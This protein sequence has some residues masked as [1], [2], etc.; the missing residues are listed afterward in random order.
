MK[1][2]TKVKT[3]KLHKMHF[4]SVIIAVLVLLRCIGLPSYS[5]FNAVFTI[6][7]VVLQRYDFFPFCFIN[8]LAILT[9][10]NS[11]RLLYPENVEE[12]RKTFGF[13]K[14][15][16]LLG[17]FLIHMIPL[18]ISMYGCFMVKKDD[19]SPH[20]RFPGLFSCLAHLLWAGVFVGDFN[21]SGMYATLGDSGWF[22]LWIVSI[23]TH[24]IGNFITPLLYSGA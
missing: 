6:I 11:A 22:I 12:L 20:T 1:I 17:D 19:T 15:L 24:V 13:S 8:A 3:P 16:F 4:T 14:P 18:L 2:Q 9:S 23:I 10:F 7:A 5:V 21:L